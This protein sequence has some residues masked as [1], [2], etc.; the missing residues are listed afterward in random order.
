MGPR[1][2]LDDVKKR[3]ISPLQ[4]F[5]LLPLGLQS[6]PS[7]YRDCAKNVPCLSMQLGVRNSQFCLYFVSDHKIIVYPH[8]SDCYL[9]WWLCAEG[10]ASEFSD[11]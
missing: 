8:Y 3:K 11:E 2:G 1:T 9:S 10:Q 7:S 4:G 5:E 6:V